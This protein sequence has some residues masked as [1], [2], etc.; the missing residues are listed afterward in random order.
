MNTIN[1]S[2]VV[3]IPFYFTAHFY[4]RDQGMFVFA[5]IVRVVR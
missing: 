5:E 3:A 1:K 2:F 4:H